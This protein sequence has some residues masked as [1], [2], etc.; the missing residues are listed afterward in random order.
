ME[1][2]PG[3]EN[4]HVHERS[5]RH[6]ASV[7]AARAGSAGPEVLV[8]ERGVDSRFLPG[9]VVFPGGAVDAADRGLAARWF[10]DPA[11]DHR[12]AAIR[13]LVEEVGLALTSDGLVDAGTSEPLGTVHAAP[14]ATSQLSQVAHWVA[15]SDV[16][17][18]FD[19]R[20]FAVHAAPGLDP[21]PDGAEAAH[22]WWASPREVMDEW[23]EG[24]RKLYWP[25]WLTMRHLAACAD[26]GAIVGSL[27]DTRDPTIEEIATLPR[28]VMEQD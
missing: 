13:E 23:E 17:V 6:A 10:G 28:S 19:A 14:P 26:V 20:Y 27:V 24:R 3:W 22:A 4:R 8:L 1:Y 5:I 21:V 16:P 25:T 2:R 11:Q 12:A 7:I 18:R 9:Y 15:P